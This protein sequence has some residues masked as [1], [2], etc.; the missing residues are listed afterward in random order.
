MKLTIKGLKR[1]KALPN[2]YELKVKVYGG[3]DDY[4]ESFTVG[5]FERGRDED[6]LENVLRLL[7]AIS[8]THTQ[9]LRKIQNFEP[10]FSGEMARSGEYWEFPFESEEQK[11]KTLE[12]AHRI[13]AFYERVQ[14]RAEGLGIDDLAYPDW[15]GDI[16]YGDGEDYCTLD[17]YELFYYDENFL[18]HKVEVEL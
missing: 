3:D 14:K 7:S 13:E 4:R 10:W 1:P 16:I 8:S 5:G 9:N 12:L 18:K 15:P 6:L 17:G 2:S 11:Q